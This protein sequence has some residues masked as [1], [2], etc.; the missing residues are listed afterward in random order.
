[1]LRRHSDDSINLSGARRILVVAGG[2]GGHIAPALAVGEYLR[3]AFGE[4]VRVRY[5][6]G[7]RAVEQQ[8]FAAAHEFPDKLACERAPGLALSTLPQWPRYA[9]SIFQ[10]HRLVRCFEPDAVL[11]M[12]GYVCAPVLTA[13]RLAGVPFFLHES[14]SV[15]G[16]VTRLF[17][18]GARK[19]FLAHEDA[20]SMLPVRSQCRVVG[21]PVRAA[22]FQAERGEAMRLF[23]LREGVPTLLVLGGSQ[24][25]RALNEILVEA[26]PRLSATFAEAGGLQVLWSCGGLHCR[27]VESQVERLGLA[28]VTVRAFEYIER[29]ELAYAAC[30][31]VLS[32]AGASTLAEL[33][34]LGLRSVLVPYPHA[35]DN[36]QAANAASLERA[37]LAV[38]QEENAMTPGG[39]AEALTQLMRDAMGR[40]DREGGAASREGQAARLIAEELMQVSPRSESRSRVPLNTGAD[41][42]RWSSVA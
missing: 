11:A 26:L 33:S 12:G 9:M 28:N 15:P 35:A 21:T 19:V 5:V 36:H 37:G 1:M 22:L 25:A 20:A 17:A 31:A 13:A 4:G 6:S 8:A 14:N 38:V 2:T 42:N 41:G 16:R 34:A 3:A 32:R 23:E 24:G 30:D 7:S 18:G 27:S 39:L 29:M 40:V 10:A